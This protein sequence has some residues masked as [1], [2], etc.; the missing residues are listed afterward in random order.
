MNRRHTGALVFILCFCVTAAG[1]QARGVQDSVT[2]PVRGVLTDSTSGQPVVGAVVAI[3]GG[4]ATRSDA[5][6]AWRLIGVK[7][8]AQ[9]LS[10]RAIRYAPRTVAVSVTPTLSPVQL[11][12]TR[13][14]APLD[15]V[16]V[17]ADAE[18]E[19]N[20]AGFR[21]RRRTRGSGTF[22]AEEDIA[23]RRPTLTSD[24]FRS[25]QGGTTIERDSLGNRYIAMR[26]NTF[27]SQRCLP[28]IFVDGMSISDPT[29]GDID[30]IVRP[31]ELFG[32]EIYRAANAPVEFPEQNGCGTILIWTKR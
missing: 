29:T 28:S 4:P 6:G 2:F 1:A 16:N 13:V 20:L 23:S 22:L 10:V 14:Q 21:E 8:G 9:T 26:S 25:V 19:R 15:T 32:I 12:M 17:V 30:A 31:N 24:L 5:Q 7:A 27:R 18:S 3:A 11:T